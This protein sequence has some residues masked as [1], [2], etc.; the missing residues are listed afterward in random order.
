MFIKIF[1]FIF[2]FFVSTSTLCQA[3]EWCIED[4]KK[5]INPN[6]LSELLGLP[7]NGP[8]QHS[9]NI[10]DT[11]IYGE[12]TGEAFF[13]N[14]NQTEK[15]AWFWSPITGFDLIANEN[16]LASHI[17]D[18]FN[19]DGRAKPFYFCATRIN[20]NGIV[21]GSISLNGDFRWFW[22]SKKNGLQTFSLKVVKSFVVDI[23]DYGNI[24]LIYPSSH[25]IIT[26]I[27][28]VNDFKEINY[29]IDEINRAVSD[30]FVANELHSYQFDLR[31]SWLGGKYN[32][33][34]GTHGP[35]AINATDLLE[36]GKIRGEAFGRCLF[37]N[38]IYPRSDSAF[39]VRIIFT[40]SDPATIAITSAK[41]I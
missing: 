27:H 23:D 35:S 28:N 10:R 13:D 19:T 7:F 41:R 4:V 31:I 14:H 1:Q 34:S 36:D 18:F 3:S 17:N 22:W 6:G 29:P 9:F 11:N 32:Y 2:F 25:A 12:A 5:I 37:H 26:N 33:R 40:N 8:A 20:N 38:K 24:L 15:V 21:A 30:W 16:I 39:Q